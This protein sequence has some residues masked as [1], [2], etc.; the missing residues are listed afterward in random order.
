MFKKLLFSI[1]F[2]I[3]FI[4]LQAQNVRLT[5]YNSRNNGLS[6]N[7]TKAVSQDS[8]GFIWVATDEGLSRFDGIS[9]Q[10][11]I[12]DLPSNY[13]KSF[14]QRRNKTLLAATDMGIVKIISSP[15]TAYFQTIIKGHDQLTDSTVL[16]PK[17]MFEDSHENIWI[18]DNQGI[19][20]YKNNRLKRYNFN[21][22]FKIINYQRTFSITETS[23]GNLFAFSPDGFT[24]YLDRKTDEFVEIKDITQFKVVNFAIATNDNSILIATSFGMYELTTD[25]DNKEVSLKNIFPTIDGS[26]IVKKNEN[27]FIV[28]TWSSNVYTISKKDKKYKV[29][30]VTNL[31]VQR[32]NWLYFD[33]YKNVFI[34]TDEGLILMQNTQFLAETNKSYQSYINSMRLLPENEIWAT[35]YGS[36]L[37]IDYKDGKIITSEVP[38]PVLAGDISCAVPSKIKPNS[39]W[40]STNAAMLYFVVNNKIERKTDLSEIGKNMF[41]FME[42]NEQ[43]IWGCVDGLNGVV[44]FFEKF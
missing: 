31:S 38:H 8:L 27:E 25:K 39:Y 17:L 19:V 23:N 7:L 14:L 16:F 33:T 42:D 2:V 15:D 26:Y 6:N 21:R 10:N 4:T 37:K 32:A 24:F 13:V 22:T 28:S 43:N 9:F 41:N 1:P 40:I 3:L 29:T 12:K 11:F 5:T 34:S 35:N 30:K 36:I 20:C 18:T 44:K